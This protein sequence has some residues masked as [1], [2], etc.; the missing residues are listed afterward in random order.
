MKKILWCGD[1]TLV[2]M[3]H[4]ANGISTV[5]S[6]YNEAKVATDMLGADKVTSVNAAI[7]GTSIGDW[8]NGNTTL[9]MPSMLNRMAL[10]EN[11]DVDIVVIQLLIND[12]LA[13]NHTVAGVRWAIQEMYRNIVVAHGKIMV[14]AT[15]CPI[16][17]P[18]NADLREFQRNAVDVCTT[19][20]IQVIDHHSAILAATKNWQAL[21]EDGIHP[22]DKL[23]QFKGITSYFALR[24]LVGA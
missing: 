13:Q 3:L 1:S 15:P 23:Y 21:L 12:A 16:N 14:F 24:S 8:C 20:G 5:L 19:L 9:G 17:R 4:N 11:A 10:A 22:G 18:E 6:Q 2:G 7:G